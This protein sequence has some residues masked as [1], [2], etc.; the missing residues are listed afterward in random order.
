MSLTLARM[1]TSSTLLLAVSL[2]LGA[3]VAEAVNDSES[4]SQSVAVDNATPSTKHIYPTRQTAQLAAPAV[5]QN[6]ILYHGG[7]VMTSPHNTAYF[8]W[9]GNWSGNDAPTIL[10]NMVKHIGGSP[11]FNIN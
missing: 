8:I 4:D 1:Q 11:W 2:S 3:C 10:E 9:Y 7:S 6:G 5:S